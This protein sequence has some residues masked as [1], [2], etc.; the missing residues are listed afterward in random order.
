MHHF[1]TQAVDPDENSD[2]IS[3][4]PDG[5]LLP[6]PPSAA[7]RPFETNS[8]IHGGQISLRTRT[9]RP[10][11]RAKRPANIRTP[12]NPNAPGSDAGANPN[13]SPPTSGTL[14]SPLT[15]VPMGM[16]MPRSPM[17]P[18]TPGI[19]VAMEMAGGPGPSQPGGGGGLQQPQQHQQGMGGMPMSPGPQVH[20]M[21]HH[22]L[23][24]GDVRMHTSP[25]NREYPTSPGLSGGGPGLR[26]H[27]PMQ[28]QQD[29]AAMM[30]HAAM[31]AQGSHQYGQQRDP[32]GVDQYGVSAGLHCS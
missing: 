15:A 13:P 3:P 16:A 4:P 5:P 14:P 12:A 22:R 24:G 28:S 11:A 17:H 20:R 9:H 26:G 1:G 18:P 10:S 30:H 21:Q 7:K 23:D 2:Y 8:A 27:D 32:Y 29:Y 19:H 6:L 25:T 31:A